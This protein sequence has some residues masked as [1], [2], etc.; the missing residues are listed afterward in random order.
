MRLL[1]HHHDMG[2]F[3]RWI[4]AGASV[5]VTISVLAAL[6]GSPALSRSAPPMASPPPVGTPVSCGA[7]VSGWGAATAD[8][9]RVQLLHV[10]QGVIWG[11]TATPPIAMATPGAQVP[12]LSV[13][14]EIANL[15]QQAIRIDPRDVTLTTC[16]GRQVT[17]MAE[18]SGMKSPLGSFAPGETRQGQ[19]QFPL[20]PDD[21][22]ANLTVTIQEE[23]R[24]GASISCPLALDFGT[25]TVGTVSAG[26]SAQGGSGQ[27]GAEGNVGTMMTGTVP[28]DSGTAQGG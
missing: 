21:A 17:P 1:H 15:G 24:A 3:R 9:V 20:D 27:S 5:A 14:L 8:E 22:P 26:C 4:A 7:P 10:Q 25:A 2:A 12:V 18:L 11:I 16:S 13:D 23:H 28:S 6:N 19:I